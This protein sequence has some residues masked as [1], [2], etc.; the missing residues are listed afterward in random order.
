MESLAAH[1]LGGLEDDQGRV[2]VLDEFWL[3]FHHFTSSSVDF[4]LDFLEFAGNV[5]GVAIQDGGVTVLDLSGVVHD[6]DL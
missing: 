2:S 5:S 4:G 1:W 3:F 6:D